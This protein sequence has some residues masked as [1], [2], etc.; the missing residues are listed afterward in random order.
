MDNRSIFLDS[1]AKKIVFDSDQ[2]SEKPAISI[3]QASRN[4]LPPFV[5]LRIY[6]KRWS[7]IAVPIVGSDWFVLGTVFHVRYAGMGDVVDV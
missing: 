5:Y 7:T 1:G 2:I 3:P 4:I 6:N